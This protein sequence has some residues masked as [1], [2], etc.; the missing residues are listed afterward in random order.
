MKTEIK[1]T[2]L[3]TK[4]LNWLKNTG[5]YNYDNEPFF[6]DVT[7]SEISNGTGIDIKSLRGV[8]GSLSKK[9]LISIDEFEANFQAPVYFIV[10]TENTYTHLGDEKL[11]QEIG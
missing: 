2:D 6:S 10:A 8:L 1:T 11:F 5:W 3:E 9:D 4:T 7:V